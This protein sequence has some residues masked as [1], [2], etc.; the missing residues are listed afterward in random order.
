MALTARLA[1]ASA[2]HLD[3]PP[4]DVTVKTTDGK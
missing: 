1:R 4:T 2:L 3:A